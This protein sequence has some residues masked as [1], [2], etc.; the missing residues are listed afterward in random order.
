MSEF[1]AILDR[2]LNGLRPGAAEALSL[3]A[4]EDTAR[5]LPV[6]ATLRDRVIT[7]YSIH[8]TK[9]YESLPSLWACWAF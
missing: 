2:A 3:A 7:S 5:I 9:L 4:I 1:D 6:A 8:Y